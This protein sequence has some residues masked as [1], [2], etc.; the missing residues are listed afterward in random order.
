MP[1]LASVVLV[2]PQSA[3]LNVG[4]F[5]PVLLIGHLYDKLI[6]NNKP[7]DEAGAGA[8]AGAEA[9]LTCIWQKISPY[10]QQWNKAG[11]SPN[12]VIRRPM[13]RSFRASE[14]SK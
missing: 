12:G 9:T 8:G 1:E 13:V 4:S 2:M 6:G 14:V 10:G 11:I 7:R 3:G 5:V